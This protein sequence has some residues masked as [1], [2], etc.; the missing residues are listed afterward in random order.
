M[1]QHLLYLSLYKL[2]RVGVGV[3]EPGS[4]LVGTPG[5]H[6]DKE[7]GRRCRPIIQFLNMI[8][9]VTKQWTNGLND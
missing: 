2:N 8:K 1:I 4:L 9:L 7:G 5:G 6:D 3:A